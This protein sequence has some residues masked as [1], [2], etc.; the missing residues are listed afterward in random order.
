MRLFFLHENCKYCQKALVLLVPIALY[1]SNTHPARSE[2]SLKERGASYLAVDPFPGTD[3]SHISPIPEQRQLPALPERLP[4]ALSP[5]PRLFPKT[6]SS[7]TTVPLSTRV[8]LKRIE[9]LG[10]KAFSPAEFSRITA[11]FLN[12]NLTLEQLLEIR[13]A[14]TKLY[15]SRGYTTSGAFIPP[16]D[17][18]NGI[19]RIQAIEGSLERVEIRGLERLQNRYV[20]SRLREATQTPLDIRQLESALQMLQQNDLLERVR[21]ELTVGTAPGRSILLLDLK[22]APP[23]GA[24]ITFDNR[25]S[26]SVGSLGGFTTL[27]YDNLFGVGDRID[28]GIALTEG[29]TS[30][31][32]SY[33]I[34]LNSSDGKLRLRYTNGRNRV[35]EQPFAPLDIRGKSQTY[36]L[37]FTQPLFR[38]PN[39]EFSLGLSLDLRRSRTFLFEDEPY[40]F[41][42]GPERGESK[43][44]ILRF[45]QDWVKR[46]RTSV[47]AARSLFSLG[48]DAIG[49]TVNN[50]GTDGRF[51]SW[52]G[53]FQ[54]VRALNQKRDATVV[55][56]TA[57]QL[58]GDS[59]LPLE[60]FSIGGV[61]T[62]R[63]YRSNQRVG[64]SGIA[65]TL[66]L[67]LPI[68]RDAGGFGLLQ[69]VPF[70]DA[71]VAWSNGDVATANP[72]TLVST[73]LGLRW[74]LNSRFAAR[75]DWGVPLIQVGQQG[76]SLQES[77]LSFSIQW[78]TF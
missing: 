50:S 31:D 49:A 76:D 6:P 21:A 4:P 10:S 69:V 45:S 25:E 15:T 71:G 29:V 36:S 59:L 55:A 61:D 72:N 35:V 26:P 3:D 23:F 1:L 54:L 20:R 14:V 2:E 32:F 19:L 68:A 51:F 56:R 62:V 8:R 39:S 66:E 24:R 18:S 27:N 74:Q 64:D 7:N 13:A 77:G 42:E 41:T 65:G 44:T 40:S 9:V 43:A 53:Q 30:Y 17:I 46:S 63:G 11:P 5:Q 48:V 52:L 67:Q 34:P 47:L 58:T 22:E 57:V 37:G 38:S 33:S 60:Q 16:Q 78:Q 70:I 12:K 75:A 73:G 28:A